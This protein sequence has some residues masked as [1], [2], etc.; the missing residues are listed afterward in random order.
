MTKSTNVFEKYKAKAV[1]KWLN[2]EHAQT[3][4]QSF[5]QWVRRNDRL[6]MQRKKEM[7]TAISRYSTFYKQIYKSHEA[8]KLA[9]QLEKLSEFGAFD[10]WTYHPG[11]GMPSLN[12]LRDVI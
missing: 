5:E 7:Q 3:T 10:E 2:D 4:K 11:Y 8:D 6:Y 1:E 9:R 12:V